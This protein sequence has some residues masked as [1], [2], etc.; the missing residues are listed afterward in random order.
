[1]KRFAFVLVVFFAPATLAPAAFA[2]DWKFST[3][4][5][6]EAESLYYPGGSL[7]ADDRTV[8]GIFTGK[9]PTTLRYGRAF[10]FRAVPYVQYDPWNVSSR[11]R[12]YA[13]A[14]EAFFQ[15]SA[16]P[17]TVQVGFNT[18]TWGDTDVFNPLD[19][20]NPRR[21]FDPLR[22]EKVGT[23]AVVVKREFENFFVEGIYIPVQRRTFLPGEN[24][25]WLPRDVYRLRSLGT[26]EGAVRLN[27]PK[28]IAYNYVASDE[29]HDALKNNFGARVKFRFPSFDWTIA[30][31]QGAALA[32][33]VGPA[34][35]SVRTVSVVGGVKTF[36][37]YPD[38]ALQA[39]YYPIRMTGT[40]FTW[41]VAGFL[42]KG[43]AAYTHV[44]NR[45]SQ[46]LAANPDLRKLGLPTR[47]W[48]NVLALERT[49]GVGAGSLT[50]LLQGTHVARGDNLDTN[51]IS[52]ARMFER[53][54]M[55]ALRWAPSENTTVLASYLRD[56]KFKGSLWHLEASYRFTDGWRA[57]LSGDLLDGPTETPIG[58]YRANDRAVA[59]LM[60]TF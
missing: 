12:F 43:A 22:S 50:A 14:P 2:A 24:S 57:K 6:L 23:P 19:V 31:F 52:I 8:R 26:S 40:S 51:S 41:D 1:M 9:A 54:G 27:L 49:F 4:A 32:P 42:V 30:G 10:R 3:G 17:W 60:A 44:I 13:D 34:E 29:T 16:L 11:E 20:V 25:R 15:W 7:G 59:S 53:A 36:D 38:I 39:T 28:D 5:E 18:F 35:I 33:E 47:L 45:T 37:V 58:T 21:Y 55:G 46:E 48:E 56:L